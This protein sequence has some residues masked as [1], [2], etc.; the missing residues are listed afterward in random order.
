VLALAAGAALWPRLWRVWRSDAQ[1]AAAESLAAAGSLPEAIAYGRAGVENAGALGPV[2]E[3]RRMLARIYARTG[4][5]RR[6]PTAE[7][8][9]LLEEGRAEVSRAFEH[10]TTPHLLLVE[11]ANL[12]ARLTAWESAERDLHAAILAAPN[13][14]YSYARLAYVLRARRD[15]DGARRAARRALELNPESDLVEGMLREIGE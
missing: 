1:M 8:R 9:A 10:S 2:S 6:L 14:W 7:E 5:D 11:G 4:D 13:Y 12:D 15:L 3:Q